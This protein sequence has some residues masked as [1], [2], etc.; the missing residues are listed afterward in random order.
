MLE[1][2]DPA[3]QAIVWPLD[4]GIL[5]LVDRLIQLFEYR[6]EAVHQLAE[7]QI[8]EELGVVPHQ[9]GARPN[10]PAQLFERRLRFMVDR[11]QP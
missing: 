7:H 9:L 8:V 5:Q 3:D 1:A 4:D 6:E 2:R 11:H 10:A